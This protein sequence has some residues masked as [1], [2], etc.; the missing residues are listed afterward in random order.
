MVEQDGA[1]SGDELEQRVRELLERGD[2]RGAATEAIG[3]LAPQALH[4]L[5]SLLR[6]E[7]DAADA[8]SAFAEGVWRGLPRFR[9]EASLRTWGLRLAWH[10]ALGVRDAAWRRRGRRFRSGEASRIADQ[11]R[12]R[13][14][15]RVERQVE[16]LAELVATLPLEDRSLIALR[17]GQGLSWAEVAAILS[18]E[19]ERV[20]ENTVSRRFS[21]LKERL[22]RRAKSEGFLG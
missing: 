21:R 12:T 22:S 2:H 16:R 15:V 5:R 9:W 19:G 10:A 1:R 13:S 20:D 4:Y 8:F 17:Y 11:I 7:D 14:F 6:D 3:A 18:R